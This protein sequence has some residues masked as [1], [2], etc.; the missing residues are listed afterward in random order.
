MLTYVTGVQTKCSCSLQLPNLKKYSLQIVNSSTK[1][2]TEPCSEDLVSQA[3]LKSRRQRGAP[4]FQGLLLLAF[5]SL[6]F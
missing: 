4:F 1:E 5:L 3:E 2:C 6:F